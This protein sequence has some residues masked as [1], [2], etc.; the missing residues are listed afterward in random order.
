[1]GEKGEERRENEEKRRRREKREGRR[2]REKREGKDFD[3]SALTS[4]APPRP[5]FAGT[6]SRIPS[7]HQVLI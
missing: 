5:S 4:F 7:E 1:M 6:S 3:Y 2:R